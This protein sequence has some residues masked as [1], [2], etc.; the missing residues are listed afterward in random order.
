[1]NFQLE[2]LHLELLRLLRDQLAF[3]DRQIT[4]RM[5]EELFIFENSDKQEELDRLPKA[6]SELADIH[7]VILLANKEK[8][9]SLTSDGLFWIRGRFGY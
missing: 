9:I 7:F 8:L 5:L 4:V 3:G 1:M 6:I 2:K